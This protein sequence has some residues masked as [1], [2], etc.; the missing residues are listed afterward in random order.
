VQGRPS[1]AARRTKLR[2]EFFTSSPIVISM[3][4]LLL[5]GLHIPGPLANMLHDAARFLEVRP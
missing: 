1:P 3:A 4:L 5:L 2:D